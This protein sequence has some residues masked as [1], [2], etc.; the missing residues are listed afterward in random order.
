MKLSKIILPIS[1]ILLLAALLLDI[2]TGN[3][4]FYYNDLNEARSEFASND[5]EYSGL[6][7]NK[8]SE[9]VTSYE[10]YKG[11]QPYKNA[12]YLL[13]AA[14][15]NHIVDF[16][17]KN[18]EL[19]IVIYNV[20]SVFN[21]KAYKSFTSYKS[22]SIENDIKEFEEYNDFSW[23]SIPFSIFNSKKTIN[24]CI[25]TPEF[26]EEHGNYSFLKFRYNDET[27]CICYEFSNK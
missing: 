15:D 21:R 17:I 14:S 13:S 2:F 4:K 5:K 26:L 25:S 19:T 10:E 12:D 18:D 24:W 16:L 7:S 27:Y 23:N 8:N 11:L 20:K 3:F 1:Y 22:G 9:F 6:E